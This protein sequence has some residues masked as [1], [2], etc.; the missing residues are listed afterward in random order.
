VRALKADA[1]HLDSSVTGC[2]QND[3]SA[4]LILQN[5]KRI[6]GDALIGA[7]GVRS[8]IRNTLWPDTDAAFSGMVTWRALIPMTSLPEHMRASV[9]ST[10]IGPGGHAVNYPLHRGEIMNFAATIEGKSW[11]AQASF[12][13]GTVEEC[14]DDFKGWHEDVQ[15]LIKLAPKLLKWGL[16][17]RE[18]IPQWTQARISLLGDAAHVTLPFLAQGAVHAIEDGMVLARCLADAE[19][20]NVPAALLR[21]EHARIGRTSKMVRG[22]TD[23]TERFHSH[24]LATET[25]AARYLEREWSAAP[26]AERYDW[27]YS[28]NANTAE[29]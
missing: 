12:E 6:T 27:L 23:N 29:I 21:Y 15:T 20:S 4:T 3:S 14:L 22:A 5:G 25:S 2:E 8:V 24:E 1:I 13:Q 28:Y 26:I 11:T 7:D 10:W 9:G 19:P 17:K 18:P 16:M